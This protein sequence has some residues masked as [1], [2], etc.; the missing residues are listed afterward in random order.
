MTLDHHE[1]GRR[2]R[3]LDE[4]VTVGVLADGSLAVIDRIERVIGIGGLELLAGHA[5]G[6]A[7]G[8]PF[9]VLH[10]I[11]AGGDV[12]V[13][14]QQAE[15]RLRAE[16]DIGVDPEQVG[17]RFLRQELEHDLVAAAGDQ[18]LAVEVQDTGK[19][20]MRAVERQAEHAGDIV[21]ADP[22]DVAGGRE[23]HAHRFQG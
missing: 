15:D 7:F 3:H 12:A 8:G 10:G 19:A 9:E 1:A 22:G 23:H 20:E 2:L 4:A 13:R 17:E 6:H 14:E 21:H 18:A 5:A 16:G 11:D